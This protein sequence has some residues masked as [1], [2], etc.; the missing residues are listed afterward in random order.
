M[1]LTASTNFWVWSIK[2]FWKLLSDWFCLHTSKE[3]VRIVSPKS[4]GYCTEYCSKAKS[5]RK[6][7]KKASAALV[8]NFAVSQ[9]DSLLV[10]A[11]KIAP[12]LVGL[13]LEHTVNSNV[14]PFVKTTTFLS[15]F[16]ASSFQIHPT[17]FRPG[18]TVH[19]HLIS[20]LCNEAAWLW[21][22]LQKPHLLYQISFSLRA[23]VVTM[24]VAVLTYSDT[25][26]TSCDQRLES[27]IF[28]MPTVQVRI[29]C[30]EPKEIDTG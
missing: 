14:S 2:I 1:K 28:S 11:K 25:S 26:W 12:V 7:R 16:L 22:Q 30:V 15:L 13:R 24:E 4:S 10:L 20:Y 27:G 29:V 21:V 3:S 23:A 9:L 6:L 8:F 18:W 19:R 5:M 17:H